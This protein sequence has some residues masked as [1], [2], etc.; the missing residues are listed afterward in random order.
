MHSSDK[1]ASWHLLQLAEQGRPTEIFAQHLASMA[2]SGDLNPL[3]IT[4]EIAQ[5]VERTAK[6]LNRNSEIWPG[7]LPGGGDPQDAEIMQPDIE[8]PTLDPEQWK[9]LE[10]AEAKLY[11]DNWG[12]A[13]TAI[14]R[15]EESSDAHMMWTLAQNPVDDQLDGEAHEFVSDELRNARIAGRVA[16][17]LGLL[18]FGPEWLLR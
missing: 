16:R 17:A 12:H 5:V 4:I 3:E 13:Y 15:R 8:Q 14:V 9:A 2:V 18:N 6:L 11:Q 7:L 1:V 10:K